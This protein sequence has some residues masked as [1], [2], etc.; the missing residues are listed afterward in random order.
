MLSFVSFISTLEEGIMF[1]LW[2]FFLLTRQTINKMITII[3]ATDTVTA[4]TTVF[5]VLPVHE[6]S[7][8][9]E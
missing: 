5:D 7:V 3:T 8:E 1:L 2:D 9:N 6:E 4:S